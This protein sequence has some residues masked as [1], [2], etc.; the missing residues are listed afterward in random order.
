M[1]DQEAQETQVAIQ[2]IA[3]AVENGSI[4]KEKYQKLVEYHGWLSKRHAGQHIGG[5]FD[6]VLN[7]VNFHIL[8][9][10]LEL[11][12]DRANK[13][14]F[15]VKVLAVAALV[16]SA[17]Q[18]ALQLLAPAPRIE[19]QQPAPIVQLSCPTPATPQACQP[20]EKKNP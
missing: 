8:R 17:I 6:A 2:A 18:V 16:M 7:A 12:E 10:T 5:Q 11:V 9:A 4:A 1:T 13:S 19:I 20:I 14:E 15:W 3:A